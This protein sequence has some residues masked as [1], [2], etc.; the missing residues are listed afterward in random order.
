[1]SMEHAVLRLL[2]SRPLPVFE[3]RRKLSPLRALDAVPRVSIRALLEDLEKL[4]W[5][6]SQTVTAST[7][8]QN[9]YALT[10]AGS[11]ELASWMGED[12][13]P[14]CETD[15]MFDSSQERAGLEWI[16]K[17]LGELEGEIADWQASLADRTA[18]AHLARL[19]DERRLRALQRRTS[20]VSDAIA[21]P[22][23]ERRL[24]VLVA[25]DSVAWCARSRHLLGSAGY[26]VQLAENAGHAWDLLQSRHFDALLLDAGDG[27][28]G[29][30]ELL[31]AARASDTLSD[32]PIV[33]SGVW[34]DPSERDAAL[35]AGADA[36]VG[37][38]D[39]ETGR[40]LVEAVD[41]LLGRGVA[42][43]R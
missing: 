10:D 26:E 31:D 36:Y 6:R 20:F 30:F 40:L 27:M 34:D 9:V 15:L 12:R 41:R 8:P 19:A 1:M 7:G 22:G 13:D 35:A 37:S 23:G 3:L 43:A 42:T 16:Q 32:L 24:R 25:V 4:G 38:C 17:H 18:H 11:D 28:L 29:A 5:I 39:R 14:S 33:I 21:E 2:M